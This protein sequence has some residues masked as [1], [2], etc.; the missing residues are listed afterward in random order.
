[1]TVRT[2]IRDLAALG[3][4]PVEVESTAEQVARYEAILPR[5]RPPRKRRGSTSPRNT[6][7][8]REF[9]L[10]SCVVARSTDRDGAELAARGR[11]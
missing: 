5:I 11:P 6:S 9:H 10:W 7:P 1:M 2:E 4:F 8:T 3:R